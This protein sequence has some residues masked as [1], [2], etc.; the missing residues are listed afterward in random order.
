MSSWILEPYD[1]DRKM[2]TL[3]TDIPL[4]IA[5]PVK[6]KRGRKHVVPFFEVCPFSVQVELDIQVPLMS[7]VIQ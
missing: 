5:T 3:N 7:F 6:G 4:N 2:L 1:Q